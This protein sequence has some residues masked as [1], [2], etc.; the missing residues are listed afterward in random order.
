M[1]AQQPDKN[2]AIMEMDPFVATR[3]LRVSFE[4]H[5]D[6]LVHTAVAMKELLEIN[7]L[8]AIMRAGKMEHAGN[9]EKVKIISAYMLAQRAFDMAIEAGLASQNAVDALKEIDIEGAV[10]FL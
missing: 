5:Q 2:I 6:C 4:H 9:A 7:D 3:R 8:R 1:K 10:E